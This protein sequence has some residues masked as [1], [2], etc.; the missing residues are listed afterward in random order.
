MGEERSSVVVH[1]CLLPRGRVRAPGDKSISHRAAM[2]AALAEGR[3]HLE[4]FLEADDCIRTLRALSAL[5]IHSEGTPDGRLAISGTSGRLKQPAG[6]LDVGNSGT[7]MRLL[8]GIIAGQAIS[9]ELRGDDSLHKRPMRRIQEPLTRMGARVELLGQGDRPPLRIE[10]GA[11]RGI[12]YEL[13]VASAQVKSCVLLA[14]LFARGRT[15]VVEPH[16][17]RDHTERLLQWLGADIEVEG[18]RIT[19]QGHA[20]TRPLWSGRA[21]A[22]PGDFSSAAYFLVAAAARE[23]ASLIVEDVGL[24]PRR[25]AFL[26]VLRR[27]GA[28][29]SISEK[30][31]PR[32]PEPVG[33]ISI[34]G[35]PLQGTE[36]GGA[37]IPNLIDEL[38]LVA[39]AGALAR[40]TTTIRDAK[41]LRVKESDRIATMVQNLRSFGVEVEERSDGMVVRGCTMGRSPT[42]VSSHGDHR[43]AMAM[44]VLALYRD[45]PMSIHDVACIQT[46]YPSFWTDLERIGA[47]VER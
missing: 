22:I 40:G 5:G 23:D 28:T 44:S 27:M 31:T 34:T 1:P 30:S 18:P 42:S 39:V 14:G 7:T 21:L 32:T 13:P 46:S 17:T 10:G 41:E 45:R 8:S 26:A 24:N 4:G 43:I 29:F 47:H 3:S 15:T 2:L 9:A 25:T 36:V 6:P 33:D 35:A 19:V 20:E 11:L 38:P 37:E 12:H 16:P